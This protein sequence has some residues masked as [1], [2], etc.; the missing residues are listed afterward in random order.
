MNKIYAKTNYFIEIVV[1]FHRCFFHFAL[2][3]HAWHFHFS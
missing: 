3:S 1:E 2:H